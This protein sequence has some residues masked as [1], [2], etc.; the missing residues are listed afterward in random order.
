MDHL[1]FIVVA[2]SGLVIIGMAWAWLDRQAIKP[3]KR[4]VPQPVDRA[5]MSVARSRAWERR[6]GA[7][8]VIEPETGQVRVIPRK[9]GQE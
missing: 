3:R 4:H 9:E 1:D 2:L 5:R 7:L 8:H 6:L